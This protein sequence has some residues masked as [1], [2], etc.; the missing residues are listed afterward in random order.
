MIRADPRNLRAQELL[1]SLDGRLPPLPEDLVLVLGGDGHMLAVIHALGVGKTYLGLNCGRIGFLLNDP[2]KLEVLLEVLGQRRWMTREVSR[3]K[4]EGHTVEGKKV[5]DRAL[6]DIYLERMT[7]QTAH[8]ELSVDG[9]LL[10]KRMVCDGVIVSTALG[11]TAY[12][13]AAGGAACHFGLR[14]IQLTPIAPHKPRLPSIVLP[15]DAVIEVGVRYPDLRPVR[16]VSDGR[17]HNDISS[18]RISKTRGRVRLAFLEGHHPTTALVRKL[19]E[20]G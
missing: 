7:G 4:L 1:K 8:L 18:V 20:V 15:D 9:K 12:A 2:P 16:A 6:N 10:V 19:V 5:F 3:L 17:D 11:S 13:L 14:C